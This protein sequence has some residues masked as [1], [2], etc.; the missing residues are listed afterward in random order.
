MGWWL[1]VIFILGTTGDI[2]KADDRTSA[3]QVISM[4]LV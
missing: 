3:D 2:Y 1:Q 4:D